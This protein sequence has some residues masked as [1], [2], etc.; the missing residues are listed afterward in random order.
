MLASMR[1]DSFALSL[2]AEPKAYP[3]RLSAGARLMLPVNAI[4]FLHEIEISQ[5]V[6]F[7]GAQ[8]FIK[9]YTPHW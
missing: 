5:V 4:R 9:K 7:L 3:K 8:Q 2:K 6:N 1:F